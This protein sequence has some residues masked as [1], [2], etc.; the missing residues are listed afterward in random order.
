M[1]VKLLRLSNVY[2][3]EEAIHKN[4][5]SKII[6]KSLNLSEIGINDFDLE[7]IQFIMI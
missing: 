5:I 1:L 2:E 6:A 3:L 7:N 4:D